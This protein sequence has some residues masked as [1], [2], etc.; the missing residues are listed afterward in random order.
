MKGKRTKKDFSK[1]ILT[2]T[3]LKDEQTGYNLDLWELKV[4]GTSWYKVTFINS[5]GVLTVTG[6]YGR[7]SFCREF[8]P[9]AEGGVSDGYWCEKLRMDS[10]QTSSK[11]DAEATKKELR[12]WIRTELKDYGLQGE[13][14]KQTK[15]FFQELID[16]A[17]DE[18]EYTYKA[19]RDCPIDIDYEY[20]PFV[21]EIHP[22]L[23]I[24]FDA[25]DEICR[26]MKKSV[27]E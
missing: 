14:L 11:Y 22:Q 5:C 15:E 12:K 18:L 19:Y 27:K 1:H 23:K 26:R 20:I 16:I 13:D 7:W 8:H 10:T 4:P 9:S 2:E 6:D 17:D 24:V 21:K 3:H 25:F